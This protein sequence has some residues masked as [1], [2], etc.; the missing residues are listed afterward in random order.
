M[1]NCCSNP[2]WDEP[3]TDE[4]LI[5]IEAIEANAYN[6]PSTST[7]TSTS[8][9]TS[10][11][12]NCLNLIKKRKLPNY[13]NKTTTNTTV[14]RLPTSIFLTPCQASLL[15]YPALKFGGQIKY[16]TTR[17]EVDKA[18]SDLL[19]ILETRKQL[20]GQVAVGFD[21]EWKPSFRRG[22][23]PGKTAIMQICSDANLCHVM[24]IIHSGIPQSLRILLEDPT[25]LKTGVG[26]GNDTVKVFKEYNVSVQAA[27]DLSRLANMKLSEPRQWSLGSLM[28]TLIGK[29]VEKPSKIRLGNW[30]YR[31]L[32]KDQ[33]H[34]AATD[35]FAS[36]HLYEVLRSLPDPVAETNK[37][38]SDMPAQ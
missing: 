35:A 32:S 6:T 11:N 25:I 15:R 19:R 9:T 22:V 29:Q 16:S 38:L 33:L 26:I 17:F 2:D 4:Q 23:P 34:Y 37:T 18:A 30:E 28:E 12:P 1:N 8:T 7:S 24:H 5:A 27:E 3:L 31:P 13:N 20:T 36:W 10:S 14:R 21:I